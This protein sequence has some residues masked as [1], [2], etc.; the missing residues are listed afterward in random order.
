MNTTFTML[1]RT[2]SHQPEAKESQRG[3]LIRNQ[4]YSFLH[5]MKG[6]DGGSHIPDYLLSQLKRLHEEAAKLYG[7]DVKRLV[8]G[9]PER[10]DGR[11][12]DAAASAISLLDFLD[13]KLRDPVAMR[14][15]GSG[16][17]TAKW[18]MN[19]DLLQYSVLICRVLKEQTMKRLCDR[20]EIEYP[21]SIQP[22]ALA[23]SL[24]KE[25]DGPF[26]KHQWMDLQAK[27]TYEGDVIH[28]KVTPRKEDVSELISWT[29]RFIERWLDRNGN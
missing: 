6:M 23:E 21:P 8:T 5:S 29:D 3:Q 13:F 18:A 28:G 15:I 12:V 25:N 26:E 1:Q 2:M 16:I 20:Y 17:E 22:G 24:R 11:L 14:V 19:Q 9:P 27:L 4:T 7:D 10:F